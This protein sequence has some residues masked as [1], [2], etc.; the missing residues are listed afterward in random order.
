MATIYN[1]QLTK[2]LTQGAK[3]QVSRDSIPTQLADKVVP[4]MEVNPKLLRRSNIVKTGT[5]NNATTTTVYTIPTTQDFYLTSAT[6]SMIKDVTATSVESTLTATVEGVDTKLMSIVGITLTVQDDQMTLSFPIP[7][8]IDRGTNIRVTNST[9]VANC[10]AI[11]CIHGYLD[12]QS[13]A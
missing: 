13:I 4:V 9:N 5:A 8:K 3:I 7:I 10:K 2:E 6:L 12:E 11:A 1:S